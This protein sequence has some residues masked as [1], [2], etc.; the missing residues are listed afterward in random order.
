MKN[1]AQ[2]EFSSILVAWNYDIVLSIKEHGMRIKYKRVIDVILYWKCRFL[3]F[4][5]TQFLAYK[6]LEH[7]G[8]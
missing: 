2:V 3:G 8:L 5:V 4:G 6:L 1:Y 7:V